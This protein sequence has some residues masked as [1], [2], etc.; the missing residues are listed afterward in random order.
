MRKFYK[1]VSTSQVEDGFLILLDGKPIKSPLGNIISVPTEDL[2]KAI[3]GEWDVEGDEINPEIMLLTRFANTN[4]DKV[5]PQREAIV[6]EVSAFGGSDLLCYRASTPDDLVEAQ[7]KEWDLI[8][9]WLK[10]ELDVGL[11]TT[12]NVLHIEQNLEDL[13][14]LQA[15]VNSLDTFILSA[16]YSVTSI[17][18]SLVLALA[19]L[20]KKIN[21]DEAWCASRVDENYQINAWGEN[22]E[23][24]QKNKNDYKVLKSAVKFIKL[25]TIFP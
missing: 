9:I 18:G 10:E 20:K 7:S 13:A 12:S 8:L 4:F 15:I 23:T 5:R 24:M 1:K 19:L 16:F 11:K 25:A 2:A 21:V 17:L 6:G 22:L 14:K 3:L